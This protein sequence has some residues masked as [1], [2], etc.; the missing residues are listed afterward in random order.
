M[1]I[2]N[3]PLYA[4]MIASTCEKCHITFNISS[5]VLILTLNTFLFFFY[6]FPWPLFS[7]YSL[8]NLKLS[9]TEHEYKRFKRV[10]QK[11]LAIHYNATR[12]GI[13]VLYKW[14]HSF[15]VISFAFSLKLFADICTISL[16][17]FTFVNWQPFILL[18][19]YLLLLFLSILT[20]SRQ[21]AFLSLVLLLLLCCCCCC[22]LRIHGVE[23]N[24][25]YVSDMILWREHHFTM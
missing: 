16:Y 15:H 3:V 21:V 2:Y 1:Y 23:M 14:I 19:Y 24:E 7:F 5:I 25:V 4:L 20:V 22:C 8:F 13:F 10:Y 6:L 11:F 9:S 18:L 12:N 17:Y